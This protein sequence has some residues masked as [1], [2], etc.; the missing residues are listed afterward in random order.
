MKTSKRKQ[1]SGASRADA[2]SPDAGSALGFPIVGVGASAGGMAT[3]SELL[4]GIPQRSGLAFVLIQH[5]EP[6]H[7]SL[8]SEVL[9]RT[10]GMQVEEIRD[11]VKVEPDHVYVIPPNADV[12]ILHGTLAVLR[13]PPDAPRPH[14]PIDFFFRALAADRRNQAIGLVLTGTGSDGSQGL[15][16]IKDEGGITFAE[17]PATAKFDGMPNAAVH[18]GVVDFVL[19]IARLAEELVRVARHP[20]VRVERLE[21]SA[22]VLAIADDGDDLR[23]LFV[24]LRTAVGADFSAYKLPSLQR[25]LARRMALRMQPTLGDYVTLLRADREEIDALCE[26]LLIHVTSFFRDAAELEKLKEVAFPAILEAKHEGGPIRLWVAGCSTGEE[27]YSLAI[28][29]LEFLAEHARGAKVP[30]QI[31]A[32]DVSEKAI[33]KARAG[34]YSDAIV[35]EVGADRLARFFEKLDGGSY[36]VRKSVRELCAFVRH[37]LASDPPFSR[38]DL[39]SCRNVLIYFNPALQQ[40]VLGA[41]HFALNLPGFLLLGRA[42]SIVETTNLFSLVDRESKIFARSAAR[43]AIHLAP[44]R[45]AQPA[46]M[47]PLGGSAPAPTTSD[48]VRRAEGVLLDRYAPPGV[49]VNERGEILHFRG[50]TGPY[51]EPAAGQPQHNLFRMAR[52]GL[53]GELRIAMAQA[54]ERRSPVRRE[55]LEIRSD[56]VLRR[57]NLV[58][59][60]LATSAD[61]RDS[62]FAVLFEEL[63]GP[64]TQA[65]KAPPQPEA[66]ASAPDELQPDDARLLRLRGELEGAKDYLQSIIAENARTNDELLAS[67]EELVA[68]NEELQSLNEELETAK[69]ELQSTNEELT[70]LNEELQSRN[71][72]LNHV[73]GDILNILASVEVPIVIVDGARRI[74]RFTPKARP[75]LNLLP[76]DVGRPIDDIKPNLRLADLDARIAEVIDGLEMQQWEVQDTEGRW[77]RLQIRPYTT[78]EKQIDGA[79]LSIVDIDALKTALLAAEWARDFAT[80]ALEAVRTPLVMLDPRAHVVSANAAYYAAFEVS[81]DE[82]VD[83]SVFELLAGAWDAPELRAALAPTNGQ[84]ARLEGLELVR[85]LPEVGRRAASLSART[86]LSPTGEAMVLLAIEDITERARAESERAR[87]LAEAETAK[88]AAE[89]ANRTKDIFLA[90]LSHELRTPLSSLLLQGQ[91]LGRGNLSG[92]GLRRVGE[93]IQRATLAQAQL[94]DDLLDVSRIVTGKLKMEPEAVELAPVIRSAREMVGAALAKKRI[95]LVLE[96]DDALPPVWADAVRVRQVLWNLLNNAIKFTPEQGMIRVSV[97]SVDSVDGRARA[98][99]RV[100]DNGIGIE[101]EFLPRVFERF[102][103]E[104]H[105]TTRAHGG[106]G[107]G[108]AIAKHVVEEHGGNLEV[109]SAGVGKGSTFTFTLPLVKARSKGTP[110]PADPRFSAA[111]VLRGIGGA[112]VLIVDPDPWTREALVAAL[113]LAGAAVRTAESSAQGLARFEDRAPDVLVCDPALADG[114]GYALLAQI[115][116]RGAERGGDVPALALTTLAGEDDRRRALA[117]GFQLH[118]AKPVDI[119]RL[120]AALAELL[121]RAKA[122]SDADARLSG[123]PGAP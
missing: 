118:L 3:F 8:L 17:D 50:R 94:I 80:S 69:E 67:N 41:F 82:T 117:A 98:R 32:T 89:E 21:R 22:A 1:R 28:C 76:T 57:C 116:A 106:L 34:V 53:L 26:D 121:S 113:G 14:L 77:Y 15:R 12:G 37:D 24:L 65:A 31:F 30:I 78:V 63:G 2:T 73:S 79:V 66:G 46:A 60:P 33:A 25:R 43:S 23:R 35:R 103:Q 120:I 6:T 47:R 109:A 110:I 19:P 38:L 114:D 70:S 71:L 55:A 122:T 91:L 4:R 27:V 84:A 87:L 56:G 105:A 59:I 36:R 40:R 119:D 83:R 5:L 107:L 81:G 68:T 18:A 86:V 72:E 61:A 11:G 100:S 93:A 42:E 7:E 104:G 115:R 10:T 74:R 88:R 54:K 49:V 111:S 95:E 90:T 96:L 64:Q 92:E 20:Y 101:P 123:S 99:V 58:V 9:R 39:V 51:L 52:E 44:A 48:V 112:S 62:S 102:S 16:A 13:R 29:L 108:L 45:D 97:D 85:D 75:I